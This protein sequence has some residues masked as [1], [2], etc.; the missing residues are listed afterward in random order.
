MVRNFLFKRNRQAEPQPT[1]PVESFSSSEFGSIALH[2]Q[3]ILQQ[4]VAQPNRL[5][6]RCAVREGVLLVLIEHLLHVEPEPQQIFREAEQ[7]V[8]SDV[9]QLIESDPDCGPTV[10]SRPLPV[11]LYLRIAGYQQPY[12]TRSFTLSPHHSSAQFELENTPPELLPDNSLSNNPLFNNTITTLQEAPAAAPIESVEP[13]I[14]LSASPPTTPRVEMAWTTPTAE[15][16]YSEPEDVADIEDI[17]NAEDEDIADAEDTVGSEPEDTEQEE[18]EPEDSEPEDVEQENSDRVSAVDEVQPLPEQSDNALENPVLLS[19]QLHDESSLAATDHSIDET[20]AGETIEAEIKVETSFTET[21]DEVRELIAPVIVDGSLDQVAAVPLVEEFIESNDR[22]EDENLLQPE[23]ANE[24]IETKTDESVDSIADLDATL[25]DAIWNEIQTDEAIEQE[26]ESEILN[27]EVYSQLEADYSQQTNEIQNNDLSS[28]VEPSVEQIVEESEETIEPP[29][30][31]VDDLIGEPIAEEPL[32]ISEAEEVASCS[33]DEP[34]ETLAEPIYLEP[35]I[36]APD[37][38]VLDVSESNSVASEIADESLEQAF[39]QSVRLEPDVDRLPHW[40]Q[41]E[42]EQLEQIDQPFDSEQ[43]NQEIDREN[44]GE[45]DQEALVQETPNLEEQAA[46]DLIENGKVAD[47]EITTNGILYPS[48]NFLELEPDGFQR[49]GHSPDSHRSY[50]IDEEHAVTDRESESITELD[51]AQANGLLLSTDVQADSKIHVQEAT[52]LGFDRLPLEIS[53][54]KKRSFQST[55][56]LSN[57][58]L[59][60]AISSF[61]VISGFYI[62]SRPCVLG[63]QCQPLQQSQ[64]LS[65]RALATIQT[66]PSALEVVDAYDQLAQANQLLETIPFWSRS[67]ATAQALIADYANEIEELGLVVK[68]LNQANNAAK[69]SL[70][71]PHPVPV[72]REVQWMWREAIALLEKVPTESLVYALAQ[73]KRSEYESNLNS[74]NNR[75]ILEQG[76]QDR[77]VMIKKAAEVTE[78]RS[79]II[80]SIDSWQQTTESWQTILDQLQQVPQGTMAFAE[81]QRLASVYQLRLEEAE[82][83]RSQ[84]E[85]SISAYNQALSLADQAR[86]LEQQEQWSQASNTWREAITTI[87]QVPEGTTHYS[88]SQTLLAPYTTSLNQAE[89]SA[90]RS[91]LLQTAQ[92]QLENLCLPRLE[93]CTYTLTTEAIRVQL[94]ARY[95]RTVAQ[96]L[97][98]AQLSG[99]NALWSDSSS[100][101][102]QFLRSLASI[103]KSAQIPIELY[104]A[105]GS[106]FGTYDPSQSGYIVQ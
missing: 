63:N 49:N 102:S 9:P 93:L 95:D 61:L 90:K 39:G 84:E 52:A 70:N 27:E 56:T 68:A 6:I 50:A 33:I 99:G 97:R 3:K 29:A 16:S 73:T 45:P 51:Q 19:S 40:E 25:L 10:H 54:H 41:P 71:P 104:N 60:G 64:Q 66:S 35:E 12:D 26:T 53:D 31:S 7:I 69:K 57:V 38:S 34:G 5:Q 2:I 85:R 76:A 44:L 17:V 43:L 72:W 20:I 42:S 36:A 78:A 37:A 96:A 8:R 58:L 74:I 98:T 103:G 87:K 15:V 22:R 32:A 13:E 101:T 55:F 77:I 21:G 4:Q 67:Y 92:P 28:S 89:S 14:S 59:I 106:R 46:Q 86:R 18:I 23:P 82:N 94:N 81:A 1:A 88:Q 48:T 91:T 105:D 83:R 62:L 24:E 75:V 65:Q 80:N 30:A 47:V 11:R 79:Q 100:Q